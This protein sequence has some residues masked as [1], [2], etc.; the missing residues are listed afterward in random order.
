[1]PRPARRSR[2][3]IHLSEPLHRQLSL[4]ALSA[5]TAGVSALAL[6]QPA[7]AQIVYTPAHEII[8]RNE[9]MLIDFN[10]DG[11]AD[12]TIREVFW[13][14]DTNGLFPGNS[15]QGK[16][17]P[18]G[19]IELGPFNDFAANVKHGVRIG[20]FSPFRYSF[21]AIFQVTS[22]GTYYGGS[23]WSEFT[24]NGFLGVRFRIR[25]EDHYGWVRM[26]IRL[27]PIKHSIEALMTGYAYETQPNTPIRAGDT[28]QNDSGDGPTSQLTFPPQPEANQPL[29]LGVLA[30]GAKGISVWRSGAPA[31]EK[32]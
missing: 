24:P 13:S 9:R 30:L 26:S 32:R 29:T 6:A 3:A 14:L 19:A 17:T 31:I 8:G 2:E 4:Y 7:K 27:Y 28:G 20:E 22:F 16:T 11:T 18:G 1:M 10:H 25:G 12:V 23:S 15:L 5:G 21:A